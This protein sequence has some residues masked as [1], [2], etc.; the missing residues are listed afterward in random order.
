MNNSGNIF[1]RGNR[2][3]NMKRQN[4]NNQ[5]NIS[6]GQ[7]SPPPA[8]QPPCPPP[9]P[10]PSPKPPQH[11]PGQKPPFPVRP[12]RKPNR[13]T[14]EPPKPPVQPPQPSAPNPNQ[15]DNLANIASK[16]LGTSPEELKKAAQNGN[17]QSLLSQMSPSQAQQI[18]KILSDEN[19]AKKLL[20]TPQA[21][22]LLRRLSKNE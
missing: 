22:E 17:V 8:P 14:Q 9:Q 13:P 16:H 20:S 21:Q 6:A 19:A 18:Q 5:S 1:G 4:P 15:L 10:S 7:T 11:R 3:P 12:P 2:Q